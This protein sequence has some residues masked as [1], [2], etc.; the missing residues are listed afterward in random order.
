MNYLVAR[1]NHVATH[2]STTFVVI[3]AALFLSGCKQQVTK[4]VTTL[5]PESTHTRILLPSAI[6][7][8][9]SSPPHE[10]TA[11]PGCEQVAGK[12]ESGSYQGAVSAKEIRVIVYLPP[13]Y[14]MNDQQYP[15][16]YA[17]HGYPLDEKHWLELGIIETIEE[18]YRSGK[19]P[20]FLVVLPQIP[21]DLNVRTDGGEGSYEEEFISGLVPYI[22]ERYRVRGG[23]DSTAL[24]GV[25]RGGVWSLEIGLRNPDAFGTVAALSP[26]LHVSYPRPAFDP[27]VIVREAVS[28]PDRLFLSAGYDEGGFHVKTVEFILLLDSLDIPHTYL[29]TPG[30]HETSTWIGIMGDLITFLTGTW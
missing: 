6:P 5:I 27:F 29:E 25:S 18:G 16:V 14:G 1:K 23:A 26:A 3:L 7:S 30:A 22:V 24:V 28:L 15:V 4:S 8:L 10:P 21:E 20:H 13:C 11:T 9:T 12:I 2:R 19:W 17:L